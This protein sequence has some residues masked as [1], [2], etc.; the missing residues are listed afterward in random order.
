MSCCV[1]PTRTTSWRTRN[2]DETSAATSFLFT[3]TGLRNG[4]AIPLLV[5]YEYDRT[6]S[7]ATPSPVTVLAR[8]PLVD[9]EG[10]PGFAESTLYR[11]PSGALVFAAGTI[12]WSLGVETDARVAR[13]TANLLEAAV[14]A[15]N[16]HSQII[17]RGRFG[18]G[19]LQPLGGDYVFASD[20]DVGDL[21]FEREGRQRHALDKLMRVALKEQSVFE[22]P[23][24]HLVGVGHQILWAGRGGAHGDEAPFHSRGEA[25]APA[26]AQIRQLDGFGDLLRRKRQ[27]L[28]KGFVAPRFFVGGEVEHLAVCR[29]VFGQG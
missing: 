19:A 17:L 2:T 15:Q 11:V 6:F 28:A 18:D 13:M 12:Y 4:D 9:G 1:A 7:E 5:G 14:G 8:S 25:C 16:V 10:R 27:P 24:L 29:D 26:T 23:R 3:G 21:G 20:E 22:R